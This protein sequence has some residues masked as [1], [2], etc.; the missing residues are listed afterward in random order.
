MKKTKSA[1]SGSVAFII[2]ADKFSVLAAAVL[3]HKERITNPKLFSSSVYI[4]TQEEA[5]KVDASE[6]DHVYAI[7]L[8]SEDMGK[9]NFHEFLF[10]H[11]KNLKFWYSRKFMD[12]AKTSLLKSAGIPVFAHPDFMAFAEKDGIVLETINFVNAYLALQDGGKNR[13]LKTD[14]S[15]TF[16]KSLYVARIYDRLAKTKKFTTNKLYGELFLLCMGQNS[17]TIFNLVMDY[18]SEELGQ[19][20]KL[21]EGYDEIEKN[22]RQAKK[23]KLQHPMLGKVSVYKPK[24]DLVDRKT[25]FQKLGKYD[26]VA[27]TALDKDPNGSIYEVCIS[28]QK[29]KLMS[30]NDWEQIPYIKRMNGHRFLIQE[31]FLMHTQKTELV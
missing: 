12:T 11:I 15:E 2:A 13:H 22:R 27:V 31:E 5:A 7:G 16:R 4:V 20:K 28:N 6:Y 23:E 14:L 25:F 17:S 18:G 3:A 26:A 24:D 9:R 8:N 30:D 19:I 10:R 29:A 1:F 21:L